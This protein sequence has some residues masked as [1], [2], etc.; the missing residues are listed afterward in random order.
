[1][2]D[3]LSIAIDVTEP[4]Q[5][6]APRETLVG[7]TLGGFRLTRLLGTGGM[8]AVYL[9]EHQ[10]I[11]SKVAVKVLHPELAANPQQVDRFHAEARAVNLIDHDNIVR[12]FDLSIDPHGRH[13][14]VMELLEGRPL[15]SLIRGP[16][17][18][19]VAIPILTQTLSALGAAHARGVIH[20]DLKP[21]NIFL[22]KRGADDHFVKVLDFGV[23]KLLAS[24]PVGGHTVAGM[25]I[26][27]PTY[28][29]PEQ[30]TGAAVDGR[31]DLYAL[32]MMAFLLVTGRLPF[33]R[34]GLLEM[35]AY[36]REKLP[37]APARVNQDVPLK[38]SDAILKALAKRPQDRFQNA[39]EMAAAF[40]AALEPS[41][42]S[43]ARMELT[44]RIAPVI[45]PVSV[46]EVS[47]RATPLPTV[48][49]TP[50]PIASRVTPTPGGNPLQ[51]PAP[52]SEQRYATRFAVRIPARVQEPDGKDLFDAL[53]TELSRGGLY[54]CHTGAPPPIF[55]RLQIV[56]LMNGKVL[57]CPC[58]VVRHVSE[59]DGLR[60]QMAQGFAVQ[61][62]NPSQ[63]LKESITEV[64]KAVAAQHP[65]TAEA[66]RLSRVPASDFYSV[67]GVELDATPEAIRSKAASIIELLQSAEKDAPS[68]QAR[69]LAGE[70]RQKVEVAR[71]TLGDPARRAEHDV[72]R[73]NPLGVARCLDA[74]LTWEQLGQIHERFVQSNA[75]DANASKLSA[76]SAG[77]W[78]K[79][80]DLE[81]ARAQ[82]EAAL[83]RDPANPTL[84]RALRALAR[85]TGQK[86]A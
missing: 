59:E 9:G 6:G 54:V 13:Y 43:P 58:E 1:M 19:A 51:T 23:A 22:V 76:I 10:M 25:A 71:V 11:G 55:T 84:H 42:A 66:A 45:A 72:A 36:H 21:D 15:S 44:P 31:A 46:A 18:A 67:L 8:G 14:F 38:L 62:I 40:A 4:P 80:G 85:G 32:G 69:R 78:E 37:D 65:G 48:R 56:L 7:Q 2:P 68:D 16:V 27:T 30:W 64:L 70:A 49:H 57:D 24:G 53:C 41:V 3:E 17:P 74:G 82:Y 77:V 52:A 33:P 5:E 81:Q 75:Y 83:K 61:F 34:G 26:G 20:R 35:L 73:R 63:D 47:G 86:T 28:M 29:A 39:A 79:R 60:W 50:A 12:I